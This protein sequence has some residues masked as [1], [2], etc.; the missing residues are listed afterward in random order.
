MGTV[1]TPCAKS[2]HCDRLWVVSS[3][4]PRAPCARLCLP[5]PRLFSIPSLCCTTP[6]GSSSISDPCASSET[7]LLQKVYHT[8][9]KPARRN[10]FLHTPP[11]CDR[12]R[13][14]PASRLASR[15]SCCFFFVSHS[16]LQF[17]HPQPARRLQVLRLLRL[18][19]HCL[20]FSGCSLP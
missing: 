14:A 9:L 4:L 19:L 6:S 20:V 16:M 15:Q 13:A 12:T 18:P 1:Q 17:C 7:C 5:L 8:C 10:L 11:P 3:C 2:G